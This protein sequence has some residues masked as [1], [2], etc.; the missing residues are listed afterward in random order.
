MGKKE[1]RKLLLGQAL[2]MV[3]SGLAGVACGMLI[4]RYAGEA[5]RADRPFWEQLLSTL[6]L[7]LGMY[8][9][10]FVHTI[11]HEAGHLVFGLLSG[12][13]FSSFRIFSF[14]WIREGE[15]V[16]FRRLT[17]AGTGGQCLMI[18]PDLKDGKLP[19]ALYNLGGPLINL[20]AG[21]V[22]WGLSFV[23][24]P[25]FSI[26]MEL[27]AVVGLLLAVINGVPMRLGAVDN[28]GYNAFVLRRDPA[29]VRAFWVQMK[30][31]QQVSQGVRLKDMPA[32]WFALPDDEAMK[33]SMVATLGVFA[34]NRLMDQRRFDEADRLME[35]M[36]S[37]PSGM[38]GLHRSLLICDRLYVELIGQ[39]RP[40]VLDAMLDKAQQ[41]MIHSMKDYP[42][43]LRTRYAYALLG[44]GDR[45]EA[46]QIRER[47]E[48]C[49]RSFPYPSEVEAER[50]LIQ[51][52]DRVLSEK[53]G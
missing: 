15:R 50:E 28:D 8:A 35:H 5:A 34:C 23:E 16:R 20:I 31:N 38:V 49:A 42:S 1:S 4:F 3:L 33:N 24:L 37:I 51:I 9:G 52:A 36:L 25:R 45:N 48:K 17:I 47:F 7:I 2:G 39:N 32:E 43:V 13:G 14:M 27:F 19:V 12:Y 40:Q 22:F 44:K 29:A 10:V 46:R 18:P 30:A 53:G 41:K 6:G 21:A 26:L 11:V